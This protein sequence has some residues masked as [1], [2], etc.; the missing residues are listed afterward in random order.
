MA[1]SISHHNQ[2]LAKQKKELKR[3][4][5]QSAK[6][7]Q[8]F[9]PLLHKTMMDVGQEEQLRSGKCPQHCPHL[10]LA[11]DSTR[12]TLLGTSHSKNTTKGSIISELASPAEGQM[13]E[14]DAGQFSYPQHSQHPNALSK[15]YHNIS[16]LFP[17]PISPLPTHCCSLGHPKILPRLL[18]SLTRPRE[19]VASP[20]KLGL[21]SV[22]N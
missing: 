9:T 20:N 10:S 19:G 6:A 2:T 12:G 11:F 16:S 4:E 13:C 21:S 5:S 1:I 7:L 15:V 18:C 3:L 22:V 17:S 8:D 14:R